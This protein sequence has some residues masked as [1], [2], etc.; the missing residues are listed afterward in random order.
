M[1]PPTLEAPTI[2]A[3][4]LE[5][6][7]GRFNPDDIDVPGGN[8]RIRIEVVDGGSKD[9]ALWAEGYA[10]LAETVGASRFPTG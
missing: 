1:S 7:V 6:L 5:D 9:R 3:A 8:A 4:A 2:A 10:R